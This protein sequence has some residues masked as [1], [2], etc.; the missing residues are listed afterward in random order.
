LLH[1][2]SGSHDATQAK[3]RESTRLAETRDGKPL[4]TMKAPLVDLEF[5]AKFEPK[6][7][8]E[9]ALQKEEEQHQRQ[10]PF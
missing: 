2:A 4:Q 6:L 8:S 10:F 7:S 5:S 9:V 1:E 3:N